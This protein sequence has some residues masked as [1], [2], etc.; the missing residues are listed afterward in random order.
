MHFE[1]SP[2][3]LITVCSVINGFVFAF[4]LF[5]KKENRQANRFLSLTIFSMCLTFTPFMLDI[6]IWNAYQWLAWLPFSLSYWIGPA[7]YFYIKTLAE[8]S[9]SFQKKDLWHFSPIILNY[10]HSIYHTIVNGANPWPWF[11]HISEIL[12]SAAI[13]SVI[14][15]LIF[16]FRLLKSYQRQLLNNVSYTDRIDLRW[17]NLFIFVIAGSC[18]LVIVFLSL[19]MISGGKYSLQEWNDPRAFALLA[20]AVI[21]YWLSINGFK[22]AQTLRIIDLEETTEQNNKGQSEVITKLNAAIE[23]HKLYRNP[24]LSLSDLSKIVDI[25]ERLISNAINQELGKNFFQLINE[26]RVEEMKER[27][28]DPNNDHLKIL[29]LAF[30]AGFNSKAS[31][32]R[33]F[34]SYTGQTPKEFKSTN[35]A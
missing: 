9:F 20:Y 1:I 2:I 28:K 15:Y 27:L 24:S 16:S 12:E 8:S 21:L 11:H 33:V 22:Q 32:N 19:S 35:S 10:L 34:K 4:L 17:V 5:E 14:I 31:F 13:L 29:S 3:Q 6:S 26:Y 18:V 25:S 30:D 23:A 7:F